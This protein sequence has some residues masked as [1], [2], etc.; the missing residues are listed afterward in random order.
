MFNN[1]ES[2]YLQAKLE[3]YGVFRAV[4]RCANYVYGQRIRLEVDAKDLIKMINNPEV[5]NAAM[6]R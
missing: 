3:L 1:Q 6:T 2:R 5:P 4:K